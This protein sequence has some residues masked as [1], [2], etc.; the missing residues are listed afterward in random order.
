[1][2]L[3]LVNIHWEAPEGPALF[4]YRVNVSLNECVSREQIP[5]LVVR[6]KWPPLLLLMCTTSDCFVFLGAGP[7]SR[8]YPS[9]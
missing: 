9:F 3:S 1:M 7:E 6:A 8:S 2:I 5:L 4:G